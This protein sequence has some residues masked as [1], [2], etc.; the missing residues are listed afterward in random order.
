MKLPLILSPIN[1]SRALAAQWIKRCPPK[2]T[3]WV[4]NLLEADSFPTIN[5]VLLP[6]QLLFTLLHSEWPKLHRV[7]AILSAIGLKHI[8]AQDD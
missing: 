3:M 6:I 8:V 5:R 2:L 4:Q 1:V 7:L